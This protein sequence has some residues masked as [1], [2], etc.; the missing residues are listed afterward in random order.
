MVLPATNFIVA[1]VCGLLGTL[2][3]AIYGKDL[4]AGNGKREANAQRPTS[5]VE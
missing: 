3:F 1:F 5:N 4:G 2:Y